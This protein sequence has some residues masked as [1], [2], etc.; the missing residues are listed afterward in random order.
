MKLVTVGHGEDQATLGKGAERRLGSPAPSRANRPTVLV[1]LL[2]AAV[3]LPLFAGIYW[4]SYWVRFEGQ[5]DFTVLELFQ[6]TAWWVVLIKLAL[7]GW[8]RIWRG[9][10]RA[11]AFYDLMSLVK[12]ASASSAALLLIDRFFA[13]APTIPRSVFLIDWGATIVVIGGARSLLRGVREWPYLFSWKPRVPVLIV[14]AGEG[15]ELVLRAVVRSRETK[16]RVIG[17]ID[18][19]PRLVGTRVGGVP[20]IGTLFEACALA[21]RH[22]AQQLLIVQ[23]ELPGRLLR[24]LLEQSRQYTFEVRVVPSYEQLIDGRVMFQPRPVAIDDL[25]R[26]EPVHLDLQSIRNWIDHR[27]LLVTGSAGSIGSEIC[28]QLLHFSPKELILVDRAETPQFFL[29]QE[30]NR[31]R[32]RVEV[33]VCLADVLDQQ[34]LEQLFQQYRPDI[35][36][37]AA[38][39]KHVPLMEEHPAEA[40][41]NIIFATQRVANAAVKFKAQSFVM[42]STD[43]A[44]NPTSVM[45]TCKRVAELY[46]QSF[47]GKCPCRFVTVRFGNVLDSAGSVVPIFREQIA[48][49][50]P[51][52]VTHPDMQRYFMTIPEAARLVIQAGALG[53]GGQILALDMGEPVR[54]MDLAMD[55]IRL[56]GYQPGRDIEIEFIGLR[57][58]EKLRE[59]LLNSGEAHV[60]T[61]HPKISVAQH[62]PCDH[63]QIAQHLLE[64]EQLLYGPPEAIIAKLREIVPE[65]CLASDAS[66]ERRVAA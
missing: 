62:R 54:I 63:R 30:I 39:Y 55:M 17:F 5:M 2:G 24:R 26:R 3:F 64:L 38:A 51:V 61:S 40:V 25:L 49:G 19:D 41:K 1:D 4:M 53:R 22:G 52:T 13:S 42:I 56:S 21:E 34:R 60:P 46:V 47:N 27:V 9:W 59:E 16:Y 28:R 65:Y 44:V 20:V 15:G 12:A 58:G 6:M 29:G 32:P 48:R 23:D 43:K 31:L 8:F 11:V 18:D 66:W 50:G 14:G 45:G 37:H 35:I 36:F 10:T 57:P 33:K 7:F